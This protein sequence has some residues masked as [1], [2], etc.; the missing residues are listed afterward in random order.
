MPYNRV[1]VPS[2]SSSVVSSTIRATEW[3]WQPEHVIVGLPFDS[4]V[5]DSNGFWC[6]AQAIPRKIE[7]TT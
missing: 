2:E 3:A 5:I 4:A 7:K 1:R 6:L